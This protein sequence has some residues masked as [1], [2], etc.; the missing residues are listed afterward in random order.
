MTK[1]TLSNPPH[2]IFTLIVQITARLVPLISWL[3]ETEFKHWST[4]WTQGEV[5]WSNANKESQLAEEL[6]PLNKIREQFCES[7]S[8][9]Y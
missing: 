3:I 2:N 6:A 1:S 5:M 9:Q 4:D 7:E 8:E